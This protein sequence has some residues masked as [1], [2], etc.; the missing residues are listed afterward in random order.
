MRRYIVGLYSDAGCIGAFGKGGQGGNGGPGGGGLGG[1][2]FAIAYR[3]EAVKQEGQTTL[4]PGTPG[5][6]GPGG[7][8][9]AADNAGATGTAATEQEFP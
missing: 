9:N 3:G 7:N 5:A 4:E 8:N 1:P 2:S 6:G